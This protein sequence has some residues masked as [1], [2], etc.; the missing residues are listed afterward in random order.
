MATQN[1]RSVVLLQPLRLSISD[2]NYGRDVRTS[3]D[4]SISKCLASFPMLT[5]F[6]SC[7][8]LCVPMT[9]KSAQEDW[10]ATTSEHIGRL[11]TL[12]RAHRKRVSHFIGEWLSVE[13]TIMKD[14]TI[15]KNALD[16]SMALGRGER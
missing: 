8:L 9:S 16:P 6:A 15:Y 12:L 11:G 7:P 4:D 1:R 13:D 14:G 3:Q 5:E 2:D 10:F